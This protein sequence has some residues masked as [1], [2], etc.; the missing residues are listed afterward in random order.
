MRATV[1]TRVGDAS[2]QTAQPWDTVG[3]RLQNF[4]EP[5]RFQF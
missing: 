5:S 4:P 3:P 1:V 2:F